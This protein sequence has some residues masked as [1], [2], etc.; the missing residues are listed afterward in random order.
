M[1][2]GHPAGYV[3]L[4]VWERGTLVGMYPSGYGREVPWWVCTSLGMG[5]RHPGGYI[6]PWV[7]ERGTLVGIPASLPWCTYHHPG[8]TILLPPCAGV[9]ASARPAL[10]LVGDEALGSN[11]GIIWEKRREE[12]LR[13]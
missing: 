13:T 6:H 5:K 9:P 1:G 12:S 10:P 11:P 3:P 7:W 2:E 4:W 8:Y